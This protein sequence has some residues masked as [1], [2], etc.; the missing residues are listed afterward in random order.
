M[1]PKGDVFERIRSAPLAGKKR[2]VAKYILDNYVE[3]SF[4]TAAQLAERVQVSEPTVI[5][6]AHNLGFRGYPELKDE[7]QQEVQAQLT[8]V[9][10]LRRSRKRM[11]DSSPA[12]QSLVGEA[13]NL[14]ALIHSVEV[15][16]IRRV[17]RHLVAA[18]KVIVIGY[19]MSSVLAE[20]LHTALKESVNNTVA[21]TDA[22]GRFQEELVFAGPQSVVVGISFP[23]YTRAVVRDF[24]QARDRGV[25]TV[26]ITDSEL[27][28]LVEHAE[29]KLLA[30][31]QAVS[32]VDAFAAAIGL[33]C[34]IAT[35]VTVALEERLVDR[36]ARLEDLWEESELFF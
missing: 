18:D 3:A 30:P 1:R 2:Q 21:V 34:A 20:Y 10:R 9:Q 7:L 6:L 26:A 17:V 28:P 25:R 15:G 32:Y 24:K 16:E 14:D 4:L 23:R 13:R 35:E 31:C 29:H 36:L 19:K 8:T 11:S 5:R 33:L 12:M 22:T 27:S